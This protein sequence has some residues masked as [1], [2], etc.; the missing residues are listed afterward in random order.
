MLLESDDMP[1]SSQ[2]AIQQFVPD[3]PGHESQGETNVGDVETEEI[4]L[5]G[6]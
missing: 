3:G 1:T 5:V 4:D 2:E 6:E